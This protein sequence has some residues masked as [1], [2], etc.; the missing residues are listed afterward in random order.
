MQKEEGASVR[1][2]DGAGGGAG[3]GGAGHTKAPA[4]RV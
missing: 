4:N 1:E 3:G 2:R